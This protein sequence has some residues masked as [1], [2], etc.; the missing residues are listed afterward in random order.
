MATIKIGCTLPHGLV[1][2]VKGNKVTINGA[3]QYAELTRLIGTHGTTD[4]EVSFWEA[5]KKE[6]A[7]NAAFVNG[8]I[9]ETKDDTSAKD[10]VKDIEKKTGF[11]QLSPDSY[12]VETDK[13]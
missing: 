9:F 13:V 7:E 5:W 2:D 12:G 11:E 3:N 10:K 6:N 1:L 8:F 4:V